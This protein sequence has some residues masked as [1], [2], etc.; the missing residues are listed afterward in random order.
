MKHTATKSPAKRPAA[1]VHQRPAPA[2]RSAKAVP[3]A[4]TS[5]A[6]DASERRRRE[7]GP[8]ATAKGADREGTAD[9]GR[10]SRVKAA[11]RE[12]EPSDAEGGAE[13]LE[14]EP[15]PRPCVVEDLDDRGRP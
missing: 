8:P 10:Q 9:P 12:G 1:K 2:K 14:G 6:E 3:H 11:M 15:D 4:D 7:E 5:A 13:D